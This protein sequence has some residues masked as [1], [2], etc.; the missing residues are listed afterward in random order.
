MHMGLSGCSDARLCF[1]EHSECLHTILCELITLFNVSLSNPNV[2]LFCA[3]FVIF[4]VTTLL[5]FPEPVK[6][7]WLS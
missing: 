7:L 3:V 1:G 5:L 6:V 2:E 4:V